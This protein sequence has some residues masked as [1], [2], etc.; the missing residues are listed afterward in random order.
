MLYFV[1]FDSSYD[2]LTL[3]DGDSNA[4]IMIGKYCGSTLPPTFI[5]SSNA[6]FLHFESDGGATETG[7][8]LGYH[9]YNRCNHQYSKI[10]PNP[11]V[12]TTKPSLLEILKNIYREN[13]FQQIESIM[14]QGKHKVLK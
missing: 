10:H 12:I 9:A 5:S 6:A 2:S 3:Y 13:Y 8:K 4:A 1:C 14:V 7:F 11:V